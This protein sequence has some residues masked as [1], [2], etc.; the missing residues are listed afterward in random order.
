[1]RPL[2]EYDPYDL[3][4]TF[5]K[6]RLHVDENND[7]IITMLLSDYCLT[8]PPKDVEFNMDI[9]RPPLGYGNNAR[10]F[11]FWA[12]FC[13]CSP[14]YIPPN[15][16]EDNKVW[17]PTYYARYITYRYTDAPFD[18][19]TSYDD[20]FN[21]KIADLNSNVV[22]N[23]VKESYRRSYWASCDP[24]YWHGG[25]VPD[26]PMIFITERVKQYDLR[27]NR[28]FELEDEHDHIYTLC[29]WFLG[30]Y[31][32]DENGYAYEDRTMVPTPM[33]PCR[34]LD[35]WISDGNSYTLIPF[36]YA[37]SPGD[38]VTAYPY[39]VY[40]EALYDSYYE[41]CPMDWR[42][43]AY[44]PKPYSFGLGDCL[45]PVYVGFPAIGKDIIYPSPR[46]FGYYYQNLSIYSLHMVLFDPTIIKT[47]DILWGVSLN[48]KNVSNNSNT[49]NP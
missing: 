41:E 17:T 9:S 12:Q 14:D 19:L 5:W 49:Y 13:D 7:Y 30:S 25:L 16:P 1:M 48:E 34:R 36:C 38:A 45:M 4:F 2:T 20:W 32:Y 23:R 39:Y 27:G 37:Y 35:F 29:L 31:D 46:C 33:F 21:E 24:Y 18:F 15:S 44:I 28:C 26:H 11:T 43:M 10:T 47:D 22:L 8:R 3:E 42:D 40:I 6:E